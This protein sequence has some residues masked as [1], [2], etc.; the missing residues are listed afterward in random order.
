MFQQSATVQLGNETRCILDHNRS[1]TDILLDHVYLWFH[2]SFWA[3]LPFL[4]YLVFLHCWSLM[5]PHAVIVEY[6]CISRGVKKKKR[7]K[8]R[9]P[10][11][12]VHRVNQL[13]SSFWENNIPEVKPRSWCCRRCRREQSISLVNLDSSDHQAFPVA[14]ESSLDAP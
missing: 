14:P 11:R 10:A 5:T 4:Y 6:V 13:N 1:C 7:K 8:D 9:K 3:V 12:Y 2:W